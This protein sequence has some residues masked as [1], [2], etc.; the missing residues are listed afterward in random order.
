MNVLCAYSIDDVH[1]YRTFC[2]VGGSQFPFYLHIL[3]YY[4][5]TT[6][7]RF[8]LLCRQFL[9]TPAHWRHSQIHGFRPVDIS[10]KLFIFIYCRKE[11]SGICSPT[12]HVVKTCKQVSGSTLQG[13]YDVYT[14]EQISTTFFFFYLKGEKSVSREITELPI[15]GHILFF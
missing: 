8:N 2:P 14:G 10:I 3:I 5:Y 12:P 15:K 6:S 4:S 13:Y 9:H 11:I 1:Y 7:T